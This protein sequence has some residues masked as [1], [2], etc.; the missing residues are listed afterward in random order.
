MP[1]LFDVGKVVGGVVDSVGDAADSLFTSD[2]E[3]KKADRLMQEVQNELRSKLIDLKSQLLEEKSAIIQAEIESESWLAK[4]WRPVAM[5]F[6]LALVGAYW[7]GIG[8]AQELPEYAVK[9]MFTLVQIGIGGYVAS[10]GMEKITRT[11][12]EKYEKA[13]KAKQGNG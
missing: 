10:R 5:L 3:R 4:N 8:V 2:E 7:L 9:K 1:S 11:A 13:Q 12:G 6:M